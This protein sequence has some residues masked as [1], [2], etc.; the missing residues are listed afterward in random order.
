MKNEMLA[1]ILAGGQGT[2]LGKL[3]KDVAKPA[4]PFG[5]RYRIIDFALSN[6]ANSNIR[7]VGV[8]TQY[9][10]LALNAHIGNG[11]AWGLDGINSGVTILQPYSST[12]GS[13]WFEGTSHAIY[14]NISYIDQQ[15][16]EYVL[17]LSGDHIYKMDYEAMLAEH[18]AKN[19]DLTVS[20]MEVPIK[21]AS[22]FGIMNI[23]ENDR[24]IEFEE[25]PAEPK[26][27]LASMGI[28]IFTWKRLREM[29]VNGYSK[30]VDME[31]FGQNV[32]PSYIESGDNVFVYRFSG[33]WK[34]VGTIDSLHEATM[35]F[36][37]R[38]ND[39][40]I[41]DKNWRIY[42]RNDISTPHYI[43]SKA[44]VHDAMIGDGCYVDGQVEH[45]IISQN[46]HI[47]D[48]ASITDSFVMSNCYIG[49][50]VKIEYAIVGEGARIG[51]NVEVI[52]TPEE[53]AV[54]GHGEV[55]GE[56]VGEEE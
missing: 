36:L 19:A 20:V 45:S 26:S 11:A 5:G 7:N 6:C 16:P 35:E 9:Q 34:D 49:K 21:E 47:Q 4:V 3:T 37:H 44:H 12:E 55:L 15:D 31:D 51:D 25:K 29:L 18:K 56:P 42:S 28:Y 8:I 38:D 24:I 41:Y 32:I 13:K 39:L 43:T 50:N 23:D 33:Y 53:I 54:I 40:D 30:G 2:R 1:L 17:I 46:V 14:Q 10:P 22:R 52:G 48:N 27:N